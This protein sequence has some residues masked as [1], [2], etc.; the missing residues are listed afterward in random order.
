MKGEDMCYERL[1]AAA[2]TIE[3]G[4]LTLLSGAGEGEVVSKEVGEEERRAARR[5]LSG[6]EERRRRTES[7]SPIL[8]K[9]SNTVHE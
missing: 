5:S 6:Q 2:C 4:H 8:I 3:S 7:F 9:Q 1:L